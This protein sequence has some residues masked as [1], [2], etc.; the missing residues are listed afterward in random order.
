M[1]EFA[2]WQVQMLKSL[3]YV[4]CNVQEH[5]AVSA[6]QQEVIEACLKSTL[7]ITTFGLLIRA[8]TLQALEWLPV[9]DSPGHRLLVTSQSLPPLQSDRTNKL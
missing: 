9:P 8:L 7:G 6:T 5:S 3:P 1:A 2:S 4:F